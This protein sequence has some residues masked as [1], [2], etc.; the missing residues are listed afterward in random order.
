METTD[1]LSVVDLCKRYPGFS[2]ENVSFSLKKGRIMGFIGR[3]GAGKTTT[4]KAI[5]GMISATSG[6]VYFEGKRISPENFESKSDIGLLFGGV[7]YYPS[8]SAKTI[9]DVTKRFF[10]RWDEALFDKWIRYFDIDLNKR[11]KELSNG[12][13]VKFNL[14]IALSHGAKLLILD[15][16]T[17]GLDPVSRDELLDCFRKI[18]D[19]YGTAVLFSTHVI[20]D[21][22]KVAD[23]ITYIQNGKVVAFTTLEEFSKAYLH[24]E[25]KEESLFPK[26]ALHIRK[27]GDHFEG[28]VPASEEKV[29]GLTYQEAHLEEIMLGIERGVENEESPI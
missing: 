10:P 21:L 6:E 18:A 9:A 15:E 27:R 22:E 3:N 12:M 17:S 25:G 8:V 20:S 5:Y 7:D 4:I 2:L 28:V 11:I 23:D 24:V 19:K 29:E 14:A 1:I 13:R 16:P 26:S